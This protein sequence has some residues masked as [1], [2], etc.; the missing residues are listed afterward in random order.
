MQ[1]HDRSDLNGIGD[2]LGT[3]DGTHVRIALRNAT[4][5]QWYVKSTIL[6]RLRKTTPFFLKKCFTP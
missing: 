2:I 4:L 6:T 1:V 5:E 3:P